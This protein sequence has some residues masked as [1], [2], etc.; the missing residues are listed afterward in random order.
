MPPSLP[1][2]HIGD[3][4]VPMPAPAAG[5]PDAAA[6]RISRWR[7]PIKHTGLLVV[8]AII[9]TAW[10]AGLLGV[11]VGAR[12]ER[13]DASRAYRVSS[14]APVVGGQRGPEFDRR[15][16]VA[17]VTAV[18][19]PSIVSVSSDV[20]GTAFTGE[21]VGTGVVIT[22]DG[23]ILT[24]AHVVAGAK[25]VRVRLAGE[26]EPR[27]A[28]VVAADPANDLAL[29]QV[30]AKGLTPATLADPSTVRVGDDAVAIG[31]AMDLDGEASVTLGIVSALDRSLLTDNGA[32]D[33][34]IQTDAAISSGNSGGPLANAAGQVVGINT[35]IA[36]GDGQNTAVDIGFAISMDQVL[37]EIESL[38]ASV[39]G[40]PADPGFLGVALNERTDGGQGAIVTH[41]RPD[42]P[43]ASAGIQ[44]GD[45][46]VEVDGKHV[47]GSG[48]V[49]G[50]IHGHRPG[51]SVSVT[52]ERNGATQ[53]FH[54]TLVA[55]PP[56]AG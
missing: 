41:V 5:P 43:A 29:L 36:K 26:R 6:E 19:R 8:A 25:S 34:L 56:G 49:I 16:D 47:D 45:V 32:L 9:T 28:A 10:L 13:N 24:N 37:P 3:P 44:T 22:S 48:G 35:A 38:R 39:G 46:L 14:Q 17:A 12:L 52:V 21:G 55:R 40:A 11:Y 4:F 53:T 50:A 30:D 54:V 31:Y 23:Q 7:R 15:I 18:L 51:E 20:A 1:P 2:P 27:P 33:G 42:S